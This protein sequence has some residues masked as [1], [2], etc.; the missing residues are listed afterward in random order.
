MASLWKETVRMRSF[1][2]LEGDITTPVL[3]IGGGMA[4][5]LCALKLRQAGIECVVAEADKIG[6][7]I[8]GNTTAKI[9]SQH[10]FIYHKLLHD[11]GEEKAAMYLHANE[12]GL[13]QFKE[14]G[15]DIQ[16]EL[17][18]KTSYVYTLK[19]RALAE[20]EKRAL[21]TLHFQAGLEHELSL[22]FPV[23]AA[24][25]F[26]DQAQF[27]PLKFLSGILPGITIYENTRVNELLGQVA[28]T[29]HGSIH[30]ENIIVTTHFPFLNKH[31]S[32]FLKMFQHRSY[33]LALENAAKVEGMYVDEALCGLSF[34]S[35]GDYLL[36]GG[37][38]HRTGKKGGGYE[39]LRRDALLFYPKAKERYRWAAQDCITLDEIP[40]IGKYS[41]STHNLFVATGFNKWGM[42]SAMAAA[43]ILTDLII[44]K[45]NEWEPVFNPSRSM[46]KTQLLKNGWEATVNLL[47]PAKKRCPHLG[48][49]LKWN[50][51]EHSWDCPCH[52]SRFE[53]NG[54][55]LDN[56]ATG[57]LPH[58]SS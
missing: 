3:I 39:A 20:K 6:L 37:G 29:D 27:H 2:M 31:G 14:L 45:N 22:P 46:L 43:G 8:T 38:D 56:P 17:E 30:A 35:Y 21:E 47:S 34:R 28:I 1:D 16:C 4:G 5:I 23:T 54:R 33:L 57:D 49:A 9:T 12:W 58:S 25:S 10:G 15:A 52:G 32:Y 51:E 19:D 11:L 48:C 41:K 7:G 24:V 40:Y 44:G 53:E 18:A 13:K 26:P 36:L 42:T 55:L 50:K